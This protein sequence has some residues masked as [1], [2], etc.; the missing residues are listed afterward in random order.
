MKKI[1]SDEVR[2]LQ[3]K[4]KPYLVFDKECKEAEEY[5]RNVKVILK[6]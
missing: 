2:L 3:K 1:Y 6:D 4:V 5:F